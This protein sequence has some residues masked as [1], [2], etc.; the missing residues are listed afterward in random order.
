MT[1]LMISCQVYL[2]NKYTNGRTDILEEYP[3]NEISAPVQTCPGDHPA[4]YTIGTGSF[5]GI[6]RPRPGVDHPLSSAEVK[7]R[8][9][10]YIY[11]PSGPSWPVLGCPLLYFTLL[12]FTLSSK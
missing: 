9:Q 7:E 5:L 10:L 11:F 2:E 3:I 6:K 4:S 1:S 12:Y 8:V